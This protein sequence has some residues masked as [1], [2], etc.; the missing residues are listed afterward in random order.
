MICHHGFIN[1]NR[2]TSLVQDLDSRR[3]LGGGERRLGVN[4]KSQYQYITFHGCAVLVIRFILSTWILSAHSLFT[5]N[6]FF[7]IVF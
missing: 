7:L 1:C 6:I 5:D 4:G 2:L 3:G